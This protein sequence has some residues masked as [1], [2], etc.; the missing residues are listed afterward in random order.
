MASGIALTGDWRKLR[1]KFERY[2]EVGEMFA[3]EALYDC[4]ELVR[5]TLHQVVNS[6]PS[7]KNEESTIKRKGFDASL[8]ETGHMKDDN[9]ITITEQDFDGTKGYLVGGSPTK[10]HDRTEETYQDIV[11]INSEGGGN[12]PARDMLNIAY[13]RCR[14]DIEKLARSKINAW[15]LD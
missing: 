5:E 13:D 8:A 12:V 11:M 9:S 10:T 1:H 6:R 14:D 15:L 3:D 7:P 2:T 4:A